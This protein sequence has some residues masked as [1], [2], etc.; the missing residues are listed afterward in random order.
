MGYDCLP[1]KWSETMTKKIFIYEDNYSAYFSIPDLRELFSTTEIFPSKPDIYVGSYDFNTDGL[2]DPLFVIPG[3]T[4]YSMAKEV[5]PQMSA[6][7]SQIGEKF[8]FLGI[9][10]GGF[11]A[12]G[13]ADLFS[14]K[15][16]FDPYVVIHALIFRRA[17]RIT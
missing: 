5:V 16:N 7:R 4:T 17:S 1:K 14:T 3:G 12:T 6:I 8:D 15:H 9:C 10:A 11:L 13:E 2:V